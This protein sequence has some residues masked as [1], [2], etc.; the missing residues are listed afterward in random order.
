MRVGHQAPA[1]RN[2]LLLAAGQRG[3]GTLAQF[4]Q[5]RKQLVDPRQG[6]WT[7]AFAVGTDQ[8]VFFDRQRG[9]QLAAFR[10]QRD[11]P[12]QHLIGR[13]VTDGLALEVDGA[14]LVLDQPGE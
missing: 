11:A 8:Q 14:R 4:F 7:G 13:Q 3:A 6:P 10:H 5:H 12:L 2:H 9:K 1:N